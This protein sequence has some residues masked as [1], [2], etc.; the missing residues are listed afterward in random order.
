MGRIGNAANFID[1]LNGRAEALNTP[2]EALTLM[3][4]I[5]A[6]Y[7]SAASGKPVEIK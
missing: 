3:K 1:K 6:M 7:D 4:I 5:D 2:E